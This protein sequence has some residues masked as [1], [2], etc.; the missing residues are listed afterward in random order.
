MNCLITKRNNDWD[1][2]LQ[3]AIT[4]GNRQMIDYIITSSTKTL[5]FNIAM[6]MAIT[7]DQ[8][9]LVDYFIELGAD[10]WSKGLGHTRGRN[11]PKLV[12]FFRTMQALAEGIY[13]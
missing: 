3:V 4:C 7:A 10:D 11:N 12:K 8:L 5:N 13:Y 6:C 1:A 9:D 2:G